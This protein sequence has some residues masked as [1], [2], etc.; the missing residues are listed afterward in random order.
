M[1]SGISVGL[2][3]VLLASSAHACD[4]PPAPAASTTQANIETYLRAADAYLVCERKLADE[5][6]LP[7]PA[8]KAAYDSYLGAY[9]LMQKAADQYNA[10]LKNTSPAS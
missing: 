1:S 5:A 7:P 9:A 2:A 4:V 10:A 3:I 8:R 6:K